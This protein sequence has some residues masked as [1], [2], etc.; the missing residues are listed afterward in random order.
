MAG[1][2][3]RTFSQIQNVNMCNTIS[4]DDTIVQNPNVAFNATLVETRKHSMPNE[5]SFRL[6]HRD[7]GVKGSGKRRVSF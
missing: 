3:G 7:P 1:K 4:F 2:N 6:K 5:Q